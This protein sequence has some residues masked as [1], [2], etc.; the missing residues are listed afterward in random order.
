M[1]VVPVPPA[2]VI[3]SVNMVF[4]FVASE[5]PRAL[6]IE[7]PEPTLQKDGKVVTV[8]RSTGKVAICVLPFVA[9]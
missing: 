9:P 8:F 1:V 2:A 5:V 6:L 3:V 4:E 7:T